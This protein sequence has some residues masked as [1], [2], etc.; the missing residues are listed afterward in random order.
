[1]RR[2]TRSW[3][4]MKSR[5]SSTVKDILGKMRFLEKLDEESRDFEITE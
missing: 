2:M 3:H 1:M 5:N 4:G